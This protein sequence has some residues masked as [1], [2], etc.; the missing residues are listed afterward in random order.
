MLTFKEAKALDIN[1]M[2]LG[3]SQEQMMERAGEAVASEVLKR[4]KG[5]RKK[6]CIVCGT[7]NNGGDGFVAARRLAKDAAVTVVLA[8]KELKIAGEGEGPAGV[9]FMRLRGDIRDPVA[10][11][12][13]ERLKGKVI[14]QTWKEAD[15]ASSDIIVDAILGVGAV[16]EVREPYRGC[17]EDINAHR[18]PVVSVDVPSGLGS[19][20]VIKA[21]ATV[22][23]HD[24]KAGM[25]KG[26]SGEIVVADVGIPN[27]ASHVGPGDFKVYFPKPRK[28]SHKG[29]NGH[30]LVVGGGPYTGAPALA[31]LGA[32]KIGA[33][34]SFVATP[35]SAAQTVASYSMNLIVAPLEGERLH[36]S[37]VERC[38]EL[39]E[40]ADAVLI[41]PGL[42]RSEETL[43]AARQFIAECISKLVVDADAIEAIGRQHGLL[44]GKCGVVTP[45]AG[46]F[47]AL[48]GEKIADSPAARERQACALSKSTGF[49]VLL[50][51]PI[52]V[53]SDGART[54]ENYTGNEAM[55]VGGTGDV[56]AGLC[57]GLMAKGASPYEAAMLAAFVNGAAGDLAFVEK[58]Y[59]LLATDVLEKVPSVIAKYL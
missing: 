47:H 31:A 44:A 56:L 4:L 3:V 5:G 14:V 34:L 43:E 11:L 37:N 52:D 48:T 32:L 33:D 55:T 35:E 12:N 45:H 54:R 20:T 1:A 51:G 42:G 58:S 53:I 49:T 22:T 17:I 23:F 8:S 6:V 16:G 24:K 7:G 30:V 18:K 10:R 36:P 39:A 59:G 27:E 28:G 9:E 15:L 57:A 46:E 40:D 13:F 26:N 2:H 38:L 50:K 29:E 25:T 19:S 41:G 21:D